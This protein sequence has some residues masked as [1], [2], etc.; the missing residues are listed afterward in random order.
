MSTKMKERDAVGEFR[1][2]EMLGRWKNMGQEKMIDKKE[3]H[4]RI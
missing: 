2:E 1:Q 3:R 4:K